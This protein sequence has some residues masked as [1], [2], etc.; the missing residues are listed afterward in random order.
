MTSRLTAGSVAVTLLPLTSAHAEVGISLSFQ[1]LLFSRFTPIC[2]WQLFRKM[3]QWETRGQSQLKAYLWLEE[4]RSSI[5]KLW[6]MQR[7]L[8]LLSEERNFIK[9]LSASSYSW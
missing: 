8:C 1:S 6:F 4:Y 5:F 9:G 7:S 3:A 2:A